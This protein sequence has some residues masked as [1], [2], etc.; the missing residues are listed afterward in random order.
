MPCV[1]KRLA[2]ASVCLTRRVNLSPFPSLQ[3]EPHARRRLPRGILCY[4]A[5]ANLSVCAAAG[6][7]S[8]ANSTSKQYCDGFGP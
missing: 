3:I 2:L 6:I 5:S 8:I 1:S 7:M 4:N